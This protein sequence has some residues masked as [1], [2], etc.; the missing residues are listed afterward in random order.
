MAMACQVA[1]AQNLQNMYKED[2]ASLLIY[3]HAMKAALQ[4]A[5][6]DKH[7][8]SQHFED[9]RDDWAKKLQAR[10]KEVW[11]PVSFEL[12]FLF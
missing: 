5:L 6:R 9:T 3:V 11:P 10:H 1:S 7:V 12:Y 8:A 2:E 4:D